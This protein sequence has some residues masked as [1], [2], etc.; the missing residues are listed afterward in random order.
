MAVLLAQQEQLLCEIVDAVRA[1]RPDNPQLRVTTGGR[2]GARVFLHGRQTRELDGRRPHADISELEAKGFLRKAKSETGNDYFIVTAEAHAERES[3]RSSFEMQPDT[4]LYTKGWIPDER[5]LDR[6]ANSV[7]YLARRNRSI[8]VL[9]VCSAWRPESERYKRFVAEIQ[10]LEE[11]SDEPGV[12]RVL[13]SEVPDPSKG[14]FPWYVMPQ[15]IPLSKLRPEAPL[16]EIVAG[17]AS[18]AETLQAMHE[19]EYS[20]RDVKPS[21]LFVMGDGTYVVGDLGLVGVPEEIRQSL[22]REGGSLGPA[23]FMAPEMLEYIPGTDARPADVYSLAKST[24]ALVAKRNYPFPGHQR[25]DDRESLVALTGEDRASDLDRLIEAATE[26]DPSRRPTMAETATELRAWVEAHPGERDDEE[27]DELTAAIAGARTR[28]SNQLSE[29]ESAATDLES[30]KEAFGQL[31]EA[32]N[33]IFIALPQVGASND[34]VR[35]GQMLDAA[36]G[37]PF[38]EEMGRPLIVWRNQVFVYAQIGDEHNGV[39][40]AVAC[41][42]ALYEGQALA[43]AVGILVY[44]VPPTLG[45]DGFAWHDSFEAP[46]GT[47]TVGQETQRLAQRAREQMPAAITSFSNLA[48]RL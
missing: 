24:W 22:T 1:M 31:V 12:M 33:P 43:S 21:N 36:L 45:S 19:R 13:D 10:A 27:E 34:T 11:L 41:A 48:E 30:A 26:H 29:A 5:E 39:R 15:G 18:V 42:T 44:G 23:N 7:V 20:H 37:H 16:D 2:S 3:L 14:Q 40:L 8:A 4:A 38:L 9:K 17:L 47:L 32:M 6:G 28:L 46:V 25:F 35:D